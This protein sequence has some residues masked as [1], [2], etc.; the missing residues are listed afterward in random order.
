LL[1]NIATIAQ[2]MAITTPDNVANLQSAQNVVAHIRSGDVKPKSM[3]VTI[4][5]KT[6]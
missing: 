6:T 3:S 5:T 4:A 2:I 1:E